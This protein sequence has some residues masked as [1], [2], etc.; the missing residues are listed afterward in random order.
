MNL[1]AYHL[2]QLEIDAANKPYAKRELMCVNL[3][4][5]TA[6]TKLGS[7][8]SFIEFSSWNEIE[9]DTQKTG[10]LNCFIIQKIF[11][12]QNFFF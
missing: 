7:N 5:N 4:D 11:L 10:P 1:T 9:P 6:R 2:I 8:T 12:R 3:S